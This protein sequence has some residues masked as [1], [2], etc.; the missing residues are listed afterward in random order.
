MY[1]VATFAFCIIFIFLL[2]LQFFML[3]CFCLSTCF[4]NNINVYK[5]RQKTKHTS[6]RPKRLQ[7]RQRWLQRL[8]LFACTQLTRWLTR[9]TTFVEMLDWIFGLGLDYSKVGVAVVVSFAIE[10]DVAYLALLLLLAG[11]LHSF[12]DRRRI[13]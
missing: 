12:F 6:Q 11:I 2:Y 8:L 10:A 1:A 13:L 7:R 9:L 3:L 4:R 5:K